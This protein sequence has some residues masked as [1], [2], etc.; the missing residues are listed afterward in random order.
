MTAL[1]LLA[2]GIALGSIGTLL[3]VAYVRLSRWAPPLTPVDEAHHQKLRIASAL[4]SKD[5]ES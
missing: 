5:G 3:V 1:A 4:M 2:A